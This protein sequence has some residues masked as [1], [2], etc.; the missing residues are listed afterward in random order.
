NFVGFKLNPLEH[1]M[2]IAS[3]SVPATGMQY[4]NYVA[5]VTLKENAGKDEAI[6]A[7]L[8][9]DGTAIDANINVDKT[10][11]D[12]NAQTV[13]TLTWEPQ[14]AI[15]EAVEAYV[16]VEYAGGTL[17]TDAVSLT[18]DKVFTLSEEVAPTFASTSTTYPAIKL[19]RS[20]AAGWNTVCLPFAIDNVEDFFGTGAKAYNFTGY[21]DGVLS[22]SYVTTLNASYP[23]IVYVPAAIDEKIVK[24]VEIGF[25]YTT[26]STTAT[27]FTGTYEPIADMTGKYGITPAAKIAKGKEGS[28]MKG[29][30]AYFDLGSI[31]A[32]VLTLSFDDMA[33]GIDTVMMDFAGDDKAFDLSGRRVQSLKKG[34]VYIING[35]AVVIK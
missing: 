11:A 22:F 15:T 31:A 32:P 5:T 7:K 25:A 27:Y 34:S 26:P 16:E 4:G 17:K 24:N 28:K 29:F 12:K 30:R 23:Y 2:E 14:T 20:F 19:E 13:V 6:T 9:V 3:S 18:I 21:S 8:Y 35:K 1:D 33:T 10:Q